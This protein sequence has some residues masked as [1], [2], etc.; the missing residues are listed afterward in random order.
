HRVFAQVGLQQ[1]QNP[2]GKQIEGPEGA[3]LFMYHLPQEFTDNDLAQ[4]F[5][6]F[7]NVISAKV[8]IDKQANLSKCFGFVSYDNPVST[9]TVIQALNGFQIGMKCLK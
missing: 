2:A 6:P 9:Q 5:V 4:T 8:F 7:G 1:T 3:N